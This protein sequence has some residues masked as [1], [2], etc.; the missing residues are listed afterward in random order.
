M[1]SV[2]HGSRATFETEFSSVLVISDCVQK[3]MGQNS[4]LAQ[5]KAKKKT[6][7]Y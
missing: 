4:K 7:C 1:N 2:W 5:I 3:I 6:K